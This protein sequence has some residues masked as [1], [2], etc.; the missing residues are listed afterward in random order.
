VSPAIWGIRHA[1]Y[2][3]SPWSDY[4]GEVWGIEQVA[5]ASARAPEASLNSAF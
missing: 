4:R 5:P 3:R 2:A 1:L